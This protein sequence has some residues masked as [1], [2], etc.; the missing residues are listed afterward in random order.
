M[1]ETRSAVQNPLR[2]AP[3]IGEED[4]EIF[5]T[6]RQRLRQ[7][8]DIQRRAQNH[9]D[10]DRHQQDIAEHTWTPFHDDESRMHPM[11]RIRMDP[12]L[13]GV[14]QGLRVKAQHAMVGIHHASAEAAVALQAGVLRHADDQAVNF[15]HQLLV[16][17]VD[18]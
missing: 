15:E 12:A 7:T 8:A 14:G 10:R 16:V 2:A 18:R 17:G 4:I 1:E 11:R 6:V 9:G 3:S 13:S 5:V